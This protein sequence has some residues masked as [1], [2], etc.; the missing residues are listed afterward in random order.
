LEKGALL[1]PI[2]WN[3]AAQEFDKTTTDLTP[4][5]QQFARYLRFKER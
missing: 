3:A 4:A 1:L 2:R 5:I